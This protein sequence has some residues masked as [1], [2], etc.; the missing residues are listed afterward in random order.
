MRDIKILRD[1]GHQIQYDEKE[2]GFTYRRSARTAISLPVQLLN[3]EAITAQ[4]PHLPEQHEDF[5]TQTY[6][7]QPV[8]V[9]I[10]K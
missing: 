8:E 10:L 2:L 6:N 1:L 7:I 9:F 4:P 5:T 3:E